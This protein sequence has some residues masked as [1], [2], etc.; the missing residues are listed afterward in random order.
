MP[1]AVIFDL[2]GTL[3]DTIEDIAAAINGSLA[4]RGLPLH[5]IP[6]LKLMVGKG[7]RHLV[8]VALPE[9][10]RD[11]AFVE[12]IRA[13]ASAYYEA[14][15]LDI[16]RPYPGIP[17]LLAE[18]ARRGLPRAILSNKPHDLVLRVVEGLF[19]GQGFAVVR[20]E[21][22]GFP[23]KPDPASALDI[24]A[25]LGLAPGAIAYVGDSN[26]DMLTARNAGMVGIGAAW[27]FRGRGELEAAGADAV[28]E[29]PL[30]LLRHLEPA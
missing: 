19:P 9:G 30:D 18:L 21:V 17:E 11:E 4:R 25:R 15:A 26:V 29:E 20:G 10:S 5:S 14:H 6:A 24:A 8:T 23:R 22:E 28:I 2:D 16:T 7:F 3:A 27:G 12:E 13:E 1:K